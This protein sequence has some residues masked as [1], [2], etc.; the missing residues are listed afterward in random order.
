MFKRRIGPDIHAGGNTS[1]AEGCPDLWE[2]ESGDVAVIGI[3]RT[4]ALKDLLPAGANCG[5]DEEIVVLPR[6]LVLNT[7]KDIADLT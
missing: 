4:S 3:R 5:P 1:A 2:L 6:S 7:R